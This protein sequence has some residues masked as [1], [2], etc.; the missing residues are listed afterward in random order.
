MGHK[1]SDCCT[2]RKC[3]DT[4]K[5]ALFAA[6]KRGENNEKL[7]ERDDKEDAK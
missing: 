2:C 1:Y 6:I 3:S 5:V 4:W 7:A